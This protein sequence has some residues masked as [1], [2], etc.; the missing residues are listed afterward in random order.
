MNNLDR[1]RK[2]LDDAHI[3]YESKIELMKDKKIN[4]EYEKF[5]IDEYGESGRY[6]WNQIIY[7]RYKDSGDWKFDAIFHHGSYGSESGLIETYGELG[8]DEHGEPRVMTAEEA[9]EIIKNDYEK[10]E[11]K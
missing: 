11:R 3:P 8:E 2:M 10:G 5:M 7:G 9:F 1:L 4:E 6:W